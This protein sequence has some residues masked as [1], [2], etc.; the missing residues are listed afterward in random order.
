ML[1]SAPSQPGDAPESDIS[2]TSGSVIK[3]TFSAPTSDG[4]SPITTYEV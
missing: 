3:V 4:G 1:A 2:V